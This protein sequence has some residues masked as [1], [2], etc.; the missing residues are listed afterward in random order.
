MPRRWFVIALLL[1]F[2]VGC[3]PQRSAPPPLPTLAVLPSSYQLED[4]E[5]VARD[6]LVAW[7]AGDYETMYRQLS[8]ASREANPFDDFRALYEDA[9][10]TMGLERVTLT[11]ITILRM[12]DA[13][14][15]LTYD[16]A[17]DTR[18]LGT[19]TDSARDLTI[20]VDSAANAWRIAWTARDVFREMETGARL[21]F[22]STIPNR[23]NIYDRNGR[24]LADQNGR[25]VRIEVIRQRMPDDAACITALAGAL[26]RE[27]T[28]MRA[29]IDQRPADWLLD[30]GVIMPDAYT[31]YG[32]ILESACAAR[33]TALPA[34]RY[35]E[36]DDTPIAPHVLGY[37]GFPSEEEI[38]A[39]EAAGFNQAVIVGRT[40]VE[41]SWDE[42]LR[43]TPGARLTLV[44]PAGVEL[45]ELVRADARAGESLWLTI[46]ADFQARVQEIVADNFAFAADS[47]GARSEG[48]AVVVMDANT[49]A[50][51]AL[52]TYPQ[53]DNN[54]Y[55]AYPIMGRS[56]ASEL[57]EAYQADPMRPEV[58]RPLQGVYAIGST[59]KTLSAAAVADSGVY[60][61]TESYTCTGIWNRDITRYD[62]NQ[63]HGRL[64]LAQSITQSCNPYYYE[65]G[66]WL[67]QRDPFLLPNYVRRFGFGGSSGITDLV[68]A[69]GVV[70]DPDWLR[71][72]HGEG[73]RFSEAVNL[74]IGQ[75]YLQV[76]PLQVARWY[77]AI[78]NDGTLPT[79]HVV[80][81]VG[82]VG[83]AL[84]DVPIE[85][86]VPVDLAPG[87]L[88]TIRGGMCAVTIDGGTADFVFRN[89]RL[90]TLGVCG[91]T[92]TA[93]TGAPGTPPHAWFAA[94][95]PR[96]NP[97]IVVVT[98]VETAGQGS[99]VAAPIAR[100]VLEAYFGLE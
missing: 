64:T 94:Y 69:T 25:V 82:L 54:A 43:G 11:P 2:V 77:A 60:T 49:G 57:L 35:H 33:F 95:A 47:W 6:F 21:R 67:D 3:S 39:L 59:M 23:A 73:W 8:F 34:R 14:A 12:R 100:Q 7:A 29:Q 74:S 62:W 85:N 81:Q 22:S 27:E 61:L 72:T 66:Y 20:T 40:G 79:P 10:A 13:V 51:L 52:V 9:A 98:L 45:R 80:G 44:T 87:V 86:G 18:L 97:Q 83:D 53:I 15:T 28:F 17:F 89:S 75:G 56:A 42:I 71:R 96:E 55:T 58:H 68:E 46:D 36:G 4:A 91:K 5:R 88:N 78:A 19:F 70:P 76:T 50:L 41:S 92:G 31:E 84:R 1:V 90:L 30:L 16:A 48:A 32:E 93:Q 38:P 63:G 37:V 24:V 26:E 99:E 65:V